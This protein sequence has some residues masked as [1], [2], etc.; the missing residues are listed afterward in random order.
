V[1]VLLLARLAWC[2][3]ALSSL[4][5]AQGSESVPLVASYRIE[6][7]LDEARAAVSGAVELTWTNT[8]EHEVEALPFHLYLNA[9]KNDRTLFLRSPFRTSRSGRLPDS[10]GGIDIERLSV[11]EIGDDDIWPLR[12]P[13]SP[14]DPHDETNIHVPLARP[15]LPGEEVTIDIDFTAHL[16]AIVERTGVSGNFYMVAQWFPKIARLEADGEFAD[17][18]FDARSEFYADFGRYDVTLD[19]P[20]HMIVGASGTRVSDVQNGDRR[21]LRYT[22][23]PAHDFAW[24]AWPGYE[25][26]TITI[27]AVTAH[28]LYPTSY[29]GL[30]RRSEAALRFALPYFERTL[31]AYPYPHLT[32]VYP[33]E[34]AAAA[35]GMEYPGLITTGGPW[36]IEHFG[37]R[38]VEAVTVHELA[39]QWFYGIV[40]SNEHRY[41]FLDEGLT[42]YMELRAMEQLFGASSAFSLAGIEVELLS[43]H[44]AF[45]Q[46]WA[47]RE[48]IAKPAPEFSDFSALSALVYSRVTVI[49]E[50]LGRVYGRDRVLN[51]LSTYA[52]AE[53]FAHPEPD[54]LFEIVEAKLG[55]DA[56]SLLE[57]ALFERGSV[58]YAVT[59]LAV[60]PEQ[61]PAGYLDGIRSGALTAAKERRQTGRVVSRVIVHRYG[62]L[63]LPVDVEL[64]TAD[65]VVHRRQWDGRGTHAVFELRGESPVVLAIVDPERRVLLDGNLLNNSRRAHKQ[66]LAR[67]FER[68]VYYAQLLFHFFGP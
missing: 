27:G 24:T 3:C 7:R 68:A 43:L 6:A 20:S 34:H 51:A 2:S 21:T 53:R 67:T 37:V 32:V 45:G 52:H 48:V 40:A 47:E 33:P 19:V 5:L 44:R 1:R 16:P 22:I 61:S 4:A 23:E 31:G 64:T 9:F 54:D 35:G 39:H 30:V 58:D 62:S 50:T 15:I 63:V 60:R 14:S 55:A 46:L 42:S 41:P 12:A 28:L 18:A 29:A 36:F 26:R 57:R 65:G 38:S 17:F 11:R 10:F 8:T 49:L 13:H 25:E 56:R 66:G 59:E